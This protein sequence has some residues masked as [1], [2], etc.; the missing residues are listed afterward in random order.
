MCKSLNAALIVSLSFLARGLVLAGTLLLGPPSQAGERVVVGITGT[1]NALAW[2]F[3]IAMEK[4]FFAAENIDVDRVFAPS[5]AAMMLQ[6]AAGALDLTVEGAFVDT[7]RGIEKGAPIA[8]VRILV[9]TPP[10]ELLAKPS[11]KSLKEL[12]GKTI[13]IGGAKDVTRIYL[14]RMLEPNG[15]KDSE[16]DLVFAGASSARFTALSSGAVDAAILTAPFNFSA[17]TAGFNIVGR[18]AD[19]VTDLPQNG[20]EVNRNWAA[21]HGSVLE[22]FL[23]AFN[24]GVAWFADQRNR[25]EAINILAVAGNLKPDEVAK[26]YDFFR[27]G[28]FFEPTGRVS[29]AKLRAVADVLVSLGDLPNNISIDRLL[30]PGVTKVSD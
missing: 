30:L 4:G 7:I 27:K 14:D 13:S 16:V 24:K 11:I 25:D 1:P 8:I 26:S 18:T 6:L 3:Y 22:T 10:Y 17:A 20:I 5:S 21:A 28:G 19:Y 2:P 9:Q 15:I 12:K 29:R 23:S